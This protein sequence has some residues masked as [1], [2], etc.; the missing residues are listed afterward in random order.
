MN[1]SSSVSSFAMPFLFP[2][3]LEETAALHVKFLV[4]Y[5][6]SLRNAKKDR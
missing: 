2:S 5:L 6:G 4:N 3:H 1:T